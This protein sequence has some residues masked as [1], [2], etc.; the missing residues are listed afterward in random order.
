MPPVPD[1]MRKLAFRSNS[2]TLRIDIRKAAWF[3]KSFLSAGWKS[4]L[5][6]SSARRTFLSGEANAGFR[7]E[8]RT[9]HSGAETHRDGNALG[10][11]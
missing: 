8:G 4:R 10:I 2:R 5:R 7:L 3:Q 9:I 11:G 1:L 6:A